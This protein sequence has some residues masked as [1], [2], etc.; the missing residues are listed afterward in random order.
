MLT[1]DN[2]IG[3]ASPRACRSKLSPL[4]FGLLLGVGDGGRMSKKIYIYIYIYYLYIAYTY[5]ML[6]RARVR[7]PTLAGAELVCAG[8]YLIVKDAHMLCSSLGSLTLEADWTSG[9]GPSEE[10][11]KILFPHVHSIYILC[12]C[13]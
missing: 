10:K 8:A 1:T 6:V 12:L 11:G 2:S 7:S 4:H 13:E 9:V 3:T 5:I